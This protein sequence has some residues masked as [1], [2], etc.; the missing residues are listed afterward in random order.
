VLRWECTYAAFLV[1]SANP[2]CF[3]YTTSGHCFPHYSDW[4]GRQGAKEDDRIGMLPD[5]DQ[6]SMT[7]YK[8]DERLVVMAPGLSGEYCW[9][10]SLSVQNHSAR[11]GHVPLPAA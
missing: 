6:G 11:I 1:H 3:Y 2:Q 10:V 8:N 5:L 9:A 7:I 4:E